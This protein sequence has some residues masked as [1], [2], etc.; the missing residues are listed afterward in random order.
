MFWPSNKTAKFTHRLST[1]KSK[2]YRAGFQPATSTEIF[3]N[4]NLNLR[5]LFWQEAADLELFKHA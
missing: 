2:C 4:V 1:K 5:I 3:L